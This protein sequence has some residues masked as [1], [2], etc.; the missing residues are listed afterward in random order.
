M[1]CCTHA[2]V[3]PSTPSRRQGALA[4]TTFCAV[5]KAQCRR[6]ELCLDF[7]DFSKKVRKSLKQPQ[8]LAVCIECN[9]SPLPLSV[10]PHSRMPALAVGDWVRLT[11]LTSAV[12]LNGTLGRIVGKNSNSERWCVRLLKGRSVSDGVYASWHERGKEVKQVKEENLRR[13]AW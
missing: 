13:E 3:A 12:A 10:S 4:E 11:G 9:A 5:R 6:C 8:Y 7:C 1:R 2:P